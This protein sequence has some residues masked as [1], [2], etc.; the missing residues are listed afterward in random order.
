M[1]TAERDGP[2]RS[3]TRRRVPVLVASAAS[4]AVPSVATKESGRGFYP[5][6]LVGE[7]SL[8]YVRPIYRAGRPVYSESMSLS[9]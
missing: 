5:T 8:P 2:G 1:T 9:N 7:N 4:Y 6:Q 3:I